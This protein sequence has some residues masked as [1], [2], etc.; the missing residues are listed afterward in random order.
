MRISHRQFNNGLSFLVVAVC[1]YALAWPIIPQ[2][3]WWLKH[4][5]PVISVAPINQQISIVN[6]PLVS[7]LYIPK[8]EMTEEIFEGS[9]LATVDKGVWRRPMSSSP[10]QGSNTVLVGHR[11]TYDGKGVFYFLD[12]LVVGDNLAVVWG[13]K[14]YDYRVKEIRVVDPKEVSV[15]ASTNAATLTLY[16]CTPLWSA[17]QRLVITAEL[18]GQS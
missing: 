10:Q 14:Q 3:I 6:K 16:T 9:S 11:F 18:I 4:S 5:A 13:G 17:E 2:V 1:F 7:T 12:K 8:L 15:E